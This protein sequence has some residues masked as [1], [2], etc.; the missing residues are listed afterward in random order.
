MSEKQE[1]N[2]LEI[3]QVSRHAQFCITIRIA[4]KYCGRVKIAT[5]KIVT[6]QLKVATISATNFET[7]GATFQC[8]QH[9]NYVRAFIH[10]LFW[11]NFYAYCK[12]WFTNN[13]YSYVCVLHALVVST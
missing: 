6:T 4:A 3:L 12:I 7:S 8:Q 2:S 11:V 13:N 5:H 9:H 1:L 10:F